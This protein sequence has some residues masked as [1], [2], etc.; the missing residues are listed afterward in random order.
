MIE[1]LLAL[2]PALLS[3]P[4]KVWVTCPSC[5]GDGWVWMWET[6]KTAYFSRK[7]EHGAKHVICG[8]CDGKG[9]WYRR[10]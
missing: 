5:N 2:L 4:P 3:D 7:Y 9:G 6:Q 1:W 10:Q 8:Q